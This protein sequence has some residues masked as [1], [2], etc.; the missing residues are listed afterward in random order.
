MQRLWAM[1]LGNSLAIPIVAIFGP[2]DATITGPVFISPKVLLEN[3]QDESTAI[4]N[5][6][7]KSTLDLIKH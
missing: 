7:L 3:S 2:S 6:A 4:Y 5:L 1:H